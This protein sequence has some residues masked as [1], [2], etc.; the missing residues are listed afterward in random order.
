VE[1]VAAE[2][3]YRVLTFIPPVAVGGVCLL[4]WRRVAPS[5]PDSS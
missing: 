5:A 2:L 3:L 1:A 4:F